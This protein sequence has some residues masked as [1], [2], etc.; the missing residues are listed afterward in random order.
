MIQTTHCRIKFYYG[1]LFFSRLNNNYR[2]QGQFLVKSFKYFYKMYCQVILY[3][4]S[5]IYNINNKGPRTLPCGTLNIH[6][7][8]YTGHT[9]VYINLKVVVDKFLLFVKQQFPINYFES[10]FKI[11]KYTQ[12]YL[13]FLLLSSSFQLKHE[14][15]KFSKEK[16]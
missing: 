6:T 2:E 9:S 1:I 11:R 16:T 14:N 15:C 10:T 13:S 5:F 3:S 4:T 12:N 7:F 8:Y